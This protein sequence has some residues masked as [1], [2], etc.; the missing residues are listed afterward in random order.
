MCLLYGN[1]WRRLIILNDSNNLQLIFLECKY[2]LKSSFLLVNPFFFFL[3]WLNPSLHSYCYVIRVVWVFNEVFHASAAFLW[4]SL[5]NFP[6]WEFNN[7]YLQIYHLTPWML[8]CVRTGR[9]KV[10]MATHYSQKNKK[11]YWLCLQS[12]YLIF[13]PGLKAGNDLISSWF[14]IFQ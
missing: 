8:G 6:G 5:S 11:D 7:K 2:I 3:N 14:S 9:L 13:S 10:N 4:C 12:S 1:T